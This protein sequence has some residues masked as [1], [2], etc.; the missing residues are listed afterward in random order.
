MVPSSSL[1]KSTICQVDSAEKWRGL[2]SSLRIGLRVL[3]NNKILCIVIIYLALCFTFLSS[4]L[5]LHPRE[6]LLLS[7]SAMTRIEVRII[8]YLLCKKHSKNIGAA[9]HFNDN[10]LSY[11]PYPLTTFPCSF[12]VFSSH[13]NITHTYASI[14]TIVT[15]VTFMSD[16]L[17]KLII[18]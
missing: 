4:T 15:A 12:H 1:C 3:I 5:L 16:I 2:T 7:N 8:I 17:K 13:Q 18:F 11:L 9:C 6:Y 14:L 10:S